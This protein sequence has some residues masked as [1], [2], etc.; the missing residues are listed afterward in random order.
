M[1]IA[2]GIHGYGRGHATRALA[3]LP[4]LSARHELLILAGGDAFNALHEHYPVVRIPTFRYHLGKGGKIS[5][6][7][8]LIRTA[9]KVMDL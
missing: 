1:R 7:R 2:Y 5:A 8:T 9:P 6:C 4:E 3:V